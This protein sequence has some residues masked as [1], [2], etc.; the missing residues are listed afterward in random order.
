MR[1]MRYLV[2][3]CLVA[4]TLVMPLHGLAQEGTPEPDMTLPLCT[5]EPR[6]IDEMVALWFETSGTP[7]AT[8]A[9]S[10]SVPDPEALPVGDRVD[11]ATLDAIS[12]VTKEWLSCME[13]AGQYARGFSL[14]S[15]QLLA[16]F[17]PDISNPEQDTPEEVKALLEAQMAGTPIAGAEGMAQVP[18]IVGPRKPRLLDDGR[19]GA[20]WSL[21]GDRVFLVYKQQEDGSWLI[22][23]AVDILEPVGTPEATPAA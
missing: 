20:I 17:G 4:A 1:T 5:A 16:Q 14:L 6:D 12:N 18:L 8:P 7:A 10:A 11:D 13:V 22:D 2:P 15:D 23:E 19:V 9:M 3:G 21:G